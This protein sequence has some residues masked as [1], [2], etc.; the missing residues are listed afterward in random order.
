MAALGHKLEPECCAL[1]AA[2]AVAALDVG[3]LLGGGATAGL[4][5]TAAAVV[6]LCCALLAAAARLA[7]RLTA[8][9]G[10]ERWLRSLAGAA[11]A[12]VVIIPVSTL[13]FQGT[14]ISARWYAPYGPF[15]VAPVLFVGTAVGLRLAGLVG[16]WARRGRRRGLALAPL[17]AA[18]AALFLW[19]DLRLYPNQYGYLHWTLL[20]CAAL[21]LMAAAWLLLPRPREGTRWRWACPALLWLGLPLAA[22][23]ALGVGLATHN[24]RQVLFERSHAAGRLVTFGRGLLDF[25]G[26]HHSVIFGET[27]CDNGDARVH[28][29][30]LDLP[31]NGIDEDCDGVDARKPKRPA[32]R[33]ALDAQ[34]YRSALRRWVKQPPLA[35]HLARTAPFDIVLVVLDAL[36]QDQVTPSAENHRNHPNLMRLLAGCTRFRRAFSN[37]SGTDIGMATVFTG[38]LDPFDPE[39][40]TLLEELQGAGRPTFGVFQR[41]VNRWLGRQLELRGLSGRKLVVNDPRRRDLGTHATARQVTDQ[42]VKFINRQLAKRREQDSR[43]PFFLWL[44]YFDV[45]EHHQIDPGTLGDPTAREVAKGRPFYRRV[46]RHV[47]EHLGRFLEQL[48]RLELSESTILV[49]LADHGEG[50]AEHPR[51]P[52]NHGDLLYT[53]LIH[54]PLAF[55]IPGVEAK[56]LDVPV[57]L[58]DVHPTLLDLAGV[59][60]GATYGISLVPYIFGSHLEQLRGFVR[61]LYLVEAKQKGVIRWPFKL[62]T[63]LDQGLVE[64]YDLSRDLEEEHNL[65]DSRPEIARSLSTLLASRKLYTID[66]LQKRPPRRRKKR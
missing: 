32:R 23:A 53:P 8:L 59:A 21:A 65:V 18:A 24:A 29:F 51:L 62:L 2:V 45:H 28:P 20:L 39:N 64:L 16:R 27:D 17:A 63:R 13:L 34:G 44:H 10:R 43:Q 4:A 56:T 22:P 7:L 57:T 58:A 52:Q 1:A 33:A 15:L 30:A 12:L 40:R 37:G 41:E 14:G 6:L 42:G 3:L 48:G 35:A 60:R 49:V 55:C 11:V 19:A 31:E 5:L 38:Q 66:R 36:R 46:L 47:D 50:L 25:D 61:P 9:V 26:D 54:V